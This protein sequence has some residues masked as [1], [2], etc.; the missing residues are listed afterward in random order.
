MGNKKTKYIRSFLTKWQAN[1]FARRYVGGMVKQLGYSF[2]VFGV[3]K[4]EKP[5]EVTKEFW[6]SVETT[7][8]A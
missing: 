1:S 5:I 3:E 4:K 7:E 2:M 8:I 6:K